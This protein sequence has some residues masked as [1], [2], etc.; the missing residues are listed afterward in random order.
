M[1]LKSTAVADGFAKRNAPHRRQRLLRLRYP[2]HHLD[3]PPHRRPART[4]LLHGV[5]PKR[6][7][8]REERRAD[9]HRPEEERPALLR[10]LDEQA[11]EDADAREATVHGCTGDPRP[12][13]GADAEPDFGDSGEGGPERLPE[14]HAHETQVVGGRERGLG[15]GREV[16]PEGE[17][18]A[19]EV[20]E[21]GAG[22]AKRE[23]PH[24]ELGD[25]DEEDDRE[26]DVRRGAAAEV[27]DDV[28]SFIDREFDTGR[29]EH[30]RVPRTVG[31]SFQ[32]PCTLMGMEMA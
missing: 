20:C 13:L 25:T 17:A 3:T 15:L 6:K 10:L 1:S 24:D 31:S 4:I 7:E 23:R 21:C 28:L 27:V 9:G 11:W 19:E 8:R 5:R 22:G 29:A 2:Y 12:Q 30:A 14:R 32:R 26:E 16:A 18:E